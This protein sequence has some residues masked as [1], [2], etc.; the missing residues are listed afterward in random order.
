MSVTDD[1]LRVRK[2]G[3]TRAIRWSDAR[4]FAATSENGYELSG[5]GSIVRWWVSQDA[6][7]AAANIPFPDYRRHM[8]GLLLL[9]AARTGL[10]LYDLLANRR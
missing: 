10:P 9:I 1:G 8:D 6:E 3:V 7:T 2:W 5:S 4:L